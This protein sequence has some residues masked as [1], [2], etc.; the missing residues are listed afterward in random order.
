MESTVV[1]GPAPHAAARP[2]LVA[3][4][5]SGTHGARY[6]GF[7]TLWLPWDRRGDLV[8]DLEALGERHGMPLHTADG[9]RHEFKW[10]KVKEQRLDFY[11]AAVDYFFE[12]PWLS[13]HCLVVCRAYVD[14]SLHA[15]MDEA[16]R[17]HFVML[18]ANKIRRALK[19]NPARRQFSI[20]VDPIA[21]AYK[22]ADEAVEVI[23]GRVV[24]KSGG[25]PR[26][27]IRVT[28]RDSHDVRAIQLCDLLLGAVMAPWQETAEAAGKVALQ[29]HVA[30]HLGWRDLRADTF[31]TSTKFNIWLFCNPNHRPHD[32]VSREIVLRTPLPATPSVWIGPG[33]DRAPSSQNV[34]SRR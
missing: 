30:H 9:V 26:P 12:R 1:S 28:T 17:K 4:D 22:K 16:R 5:E 23:T 33:T 6:Y 8:R 19:K 14:R 13:F 15:S 25:D 3:C 21:S 2:W 27:D 24:N 18:L 10:N 34:R 7:G 20:W 11:K 31:E 32:V 29:R